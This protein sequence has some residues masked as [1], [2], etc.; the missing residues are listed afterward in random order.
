MQTKHVPELIDADNRAWDEQLIN[1]MFWPIDAQR[2]LN[3]PLALGLMDDF[4]C[5]CG[6]VF[7]K[8]QQIISERKKK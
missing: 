7:Q 1:D 8:E 2:I 5:K 4:V 6:Y 3:I